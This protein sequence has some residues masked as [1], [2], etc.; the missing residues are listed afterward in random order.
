[1][2]IN[3]GFSTFL[4]KILSA[5]KTKSISILYIEELEGFTGPG[6]RNPAKRLNMVWTAVANMEATLIF[7]LTE[8]ISIPRYTKYR[9][10]QN[11][12]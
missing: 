9:R 7:E 3:A 6:S 1:V 4:S 11:V 8:T 5:Y 10:V 12:A 2:F